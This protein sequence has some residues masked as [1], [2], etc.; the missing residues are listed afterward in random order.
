ML[1]NAEWKLGHF[2][3]EIGSFLMVTSLIRWHSALSLMGKTGRKVGSAF[4]DSQA[5]N[6]WPFMI[7]RF[8]PPF[9]LQTALEPP[10][11]AQYRN[12]G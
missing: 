5:W 4:G 9:H 10:K 11:C 6:E 7:A 8:Q 12:L 3:R 2:R 1:H